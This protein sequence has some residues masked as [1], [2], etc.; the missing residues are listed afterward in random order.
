LPRAVGE[1]LGARTRLPG[2][3]DL[4]AALWALHLQS[5][6][7]WSGDTGG[8]EASDPTDRY[9]IDLE[10]RWEILDWLFA[11]L[12]VSLSHAEYTQD[13]GNGSA[14]ALAPTRT[15]MG[16]LTARH[17]LGIEAAL[18]LRHIGDRAANQEATIT[19]PGYTIV[20]LHLAYKTKRFEVGVIVENLADAEW[21]EAQFDDTSRLAGPPY[22]ETKPVEGI[23]FTPGNPRNGRVFATIFF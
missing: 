18:R 7:V 16:G 1:E 10:A 4:A 6:Q 17:P 13:R 8:T 2:K 22:N 23:H 5:E 19:A 11:D 9:G 12:D 21:R 15:I 3:V 14:V 20:D